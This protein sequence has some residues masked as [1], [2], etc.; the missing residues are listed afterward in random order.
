MAAHTKITGLF[1]TLLV[2]LLP[3]FALANDVNFSV[4]PA[5]I[6]IDNLR[7]GETAEFE[8]AINNKDDIGRNFTITTFQPMEDERREG[9]TAFPDDNWIS[10][11]SSEIELAAKSEVNITVKIAISREQKW[12][13]RDWE[14]WLGITSETGD[15]L[16]A[17]LYSRLLVSTSSTMD[18][19]FN[20]GLIAGIIAGTALLG[21]GAHYYFRR[22]TRYE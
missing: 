12:I 10:L 9:R 17:K 20:A 19:R 15:L 13:G 7:P 14:I 5:E 22:R 3:S 4:S 11:S 2:I 21:C 6:H 16:A 1:A 18:A 8:L